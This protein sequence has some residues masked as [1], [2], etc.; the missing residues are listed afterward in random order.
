MATSDSDVLS[1][2]SYLSLDRDAEI[3]DPCCNGCNLTIEE[4]SVVAFGG[5]I[6]HVGCFRCAKCNRQVSHN[7]DVLLL[8]DGSPVCDK[9]SCNCKVCNKHIDGFAIMTGNETYH[10]E[11]FRCDACKRKIEDLVFAKTNQGIYCMSCHNNKMEQNKSFEKESQFPVTFGALNKSLPSIPKSSTTNRLNLQTSSTASAVHD[12]V[13]GR[14]YIRFSPKIS[15]TEL[16]NVNQ[17]F[18]EFENEDNLNSKNDLMGLPP[19]LS[20]HE[21]SDFFDF[22]KTTI[23]SET[24]YTSKTRN[25]ASDNTIVNI[26]NSN[27]T[28]INTTNVNTF[29]TETSV[30]TS[31]PENSLLLPNYENSLSTEGVSETEK[32]TEEKPIEEFLSEEFF[33]SK[34]F[35]DLTNFL[36]IKD[37]Q[38]SGHIPPLK[39]NTRNTSLIGNNGNRYSISLEN[40]SKN[41]KPDFEENIYS[42]NFS[43][44]YS[45]PFHLS[46]SALA[47]KIS[48]DSSYIVNNIPKKHEFFDFKSHNKDY[49]SKDLDFDISFKKNQGYNYHSKIPPIHSDS[50][51]ASPSSTRLEI[52]NSPK[53]LTSNETNIN[54]LE[55]KVSNASLEVPCME[56]S[57]LQQFE[58]DICDYDGNYIRN[59]TLERNNSN[60]SYS[61]ILSVIRHRK[62]ASESKRKT[63]KNSAFLKHSRIHKSQLQPSYLDLNESSEIIED[64]E[65]KDQ[66]KTENSYFLKKPEI[67]TTDNESTSLDKDILKKKTLLVELDAKREIA[68]QELKVLENEQ[69]VSQ[70]CI[71]SNEIFINTI[72]S[73]LSTSLKNLKNNFQ[74]EIETLI[75]QRN[76]LYEEN[77]QLQNLRSKI[78]QDVHQLNFKKLELRDLNDKLVQKI[79]DQFRTYKGSG[80]ASPVGANNLFRN[81]NTKPLPP[82]ITPVSKSSNNDNFDSISYTESV[83]TPASEKAKLEY[84]ESSDD[85]SLSKIP[86]K[87]E[88]RS[89]DNKI[90]A[91][92]KSTAL[93]KN[94]VKGFNKTRMSE[95]NDIHNEC[96]NTSLLSSLNNLTFNNSLSSNNLK[97]TFSTYTF[98]RITK[99]DYCGGKLWGNEMRCLGCGI[100][101]HIKCIGDIVTNCNKSSEYLPYHEDTS[102]TSNPVN[103]YVSTLF[104]ND[105][106][107]QI[108]VENRN[109]PFIVTKCIDEVEKRGMFFEG[110]YRKSGSASQMRSLVDAFNRNDVNSLSQSKF[111][112]ISVITSVLKQYFRKLPNPLITYDAY[113]PFLEIA[114]S[115]KTWMEKL[116]LIKDVLSIL[117]KAHY[118]C[119]EFLILHLFS[120]V[121][122]HSE[123]NLMSSK[124]LAVVF[125][126]TLLRDESGM[127]DIIDIQAKNIGMQYL[128]DN[129]ESIFGDSSKEEH[130]NNGFI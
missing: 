1:V 99:C 38:K 41:V 23:N 102:Y 84:T 4:G 27:V 91:W 49:N 98:L 70:D 30:L 62:S 26:A 14:P 9:C 40:N 64:N 93:T 106:T 7:S 94:L 108:Q 8:F 88:N 120:R 100:P 118:D 105:L 2:S 122:K 42:H 130:E 37:L 74:S 54:L 28:N 46:I 32:H 104:G 25:L 10:S 60:Q 72:I 47:Q 128:L 6:W 5:H 53:D 50:K 16:L 86:N 22:P 18:P 76:A 109:I 121:T 129:A 95:N 113:K 21:P 52:S 89:L 103:L 45:Y 35:N 116:E 66:Q 12:E 96:G 112:D 11:C 71:I 68:L 107:K 85:N 117:P 87:D 73:K 111:E 36:K 65:K 59:Q 57:S 69:L 83:S 75:L 31:N 126:P 58:K 15:Q 3:P 97:H 124:N 44:K 43:S 125:S 17:L 13:T 55:S 19:I 79:Q 39:A 81:E 127:R 101:C 63:S 48:N 119:L 29:S 34:K 92:K 24:E 51:S 20:C 114:V 61:K 77:T 56:Y 78:T 80:G 115:N 90:S 110:I 82:I 33:N 67:K 123:K